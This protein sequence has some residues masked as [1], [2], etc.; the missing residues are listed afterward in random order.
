MLLAMPRRPLLLRCLLRFEFEGQLVDLAGELERNI[1][2]IFHQRDPGAGVLADVEGFVLRE[3]DRGG[4]VHGISG[5]FPA[6]HGEHTCPSLA[7]TW[8]VSLEVKDDGVLAGFQ[9]RPLPYRTLEVEQVVE[10]HHPAPVN[11]EFALTQEQAIANGNASTADIRSLSGLSR[12]ELR[13][14]WI[15]EFAAPPWGSSRDKYSMI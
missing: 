7:Q 1:V 5:N 10:E 15:Q 14:L 8:T 11:A 6:V 3:G 2:A 9:L 13:A 12:S 4:V